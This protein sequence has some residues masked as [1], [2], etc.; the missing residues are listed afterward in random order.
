MEDLWKEAGIT[1]DQERK[2]S[3]GKYADADCEEEW[4]ALES[5]DRS[6][7]W[8]EFKAELLENYPEAAAAKRGTLYK[9]RQ[10]CSDICLFRLFYFTE[11]W[12]YSL[13]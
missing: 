11:D 9:L 10:I 13:K 4:K 3:I 6:Y 1:N 7:T 8:E 5:F 12:S 2:K